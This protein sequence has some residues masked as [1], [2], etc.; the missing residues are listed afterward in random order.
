MELPKLPIGVHGTHIRRYCSY[1]PILYSGNVL[2]LGVLF[3][4]L[5][6]QNWL[7]KKV[8]HM[9]RLI[10]KGNTLYVTNVSKISQTI[11][12]IHQTFPLPNIPM[13]ST[14]SVLL[15][16]INIMGIITTHIC[17]YNYY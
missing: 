7:V 17:S 12:Q 4:V 6:C 9:D 3:G 1:Q 11:H 10:H 5:P 16:S 13:H 8:L 2:Q 14:L 15:L